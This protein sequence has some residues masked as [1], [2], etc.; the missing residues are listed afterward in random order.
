[1]L[2][3]NIHIELYLDEQ[4]AQYTIKSVPVFLYAVTI[5]IFQIKRI[6]LREKWGT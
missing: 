2:K 6:I 1:M 4:N 5:L 3:V